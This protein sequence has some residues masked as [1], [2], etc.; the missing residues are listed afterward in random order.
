M[1][2]TIAVLLAL[3]LLSPI[4][5]LSAT[6]DALAERMLALEAKEEIR[7]L[8]FNYGRYVDD[9]NWEAFAALFATDGGTWNG[10]MGI[11]K[12]HDEIVQMMSSTIGTE[13]VLELSDRSNV[14][15]P[16]CA[17]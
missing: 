4:A 6:D 16:D 1:K 14:S 9:R 7:A 3:S 12:G 10:G 2:T 13:I 5:A 8:L 11:A 15:V 17:V